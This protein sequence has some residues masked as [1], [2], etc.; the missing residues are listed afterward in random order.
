MEISEW[1]YSESVG[2]LPM[3]QQRDRA[4]LA[5]ALGAPLPVRALDDAIAHLEGVEQN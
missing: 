5:V 3:L 1:T 4:F 2:V